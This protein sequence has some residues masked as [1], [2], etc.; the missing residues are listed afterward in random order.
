MI[1][2]LFSVVPNEVT[3]TTICAWYNRRDSYIRVSCAQVCSEVIP[4][5]L[6]ISSYQAP[7]G[8][9]M[10]TMMILGLLLGPSFAKTWLRWQVMKKPWMP[11]TSLTLSTQLLM[12]AAAL[13]VWEDCWCA[14]CILLSRWQLLSRQVPLFDLLFE[15]LPQ[16]PV[17][18]K[19]S[20]PFHPGASTRAKAKNNVALYFF[21]N[22][23]DLHPWYC[24]FEQNIIQRFPTHLPSFQNVQSYSHLWFLFGVKVLLH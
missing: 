4:G 13:D 12:F 22:S 1:V 2:L 10:W 8:W 5:A 18:L 20:Q 11:A 16:S 6:F 15:G 17:Q 3:C 14:F 23:F 21:L 24:S 7:K 9:M 19:I